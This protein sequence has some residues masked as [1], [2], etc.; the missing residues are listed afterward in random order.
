MNRSAAPAEE[1]RPMLRLE[2]A[3]RRPACLPQPGPAAAHRLPSLWLWQEKAE[4]AAKPP[5]K[6]VSTYAP[7]KGL[8]E[9]EVI[10]EEEFDA[11]RHAHRAKGGDHDSD[12]FEEETLPKHMRTGDLGEMLQ[13]AHLDHRIQ[14][15]FDGDTDDEGRGRTRHRRPARRRRPASAATATCADAMDAAVRPPR[16]R[17]TAAADPRAAPRSSPTCPS[18]AT[19]SSPARRFS[20]RSPRSL[21]PRRARASPRTSRCPAAS[22]SSCPPSRTSASAARSPPTRSASA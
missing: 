8:I 2:R 14:L 22:W 10:E 6:P 18:S 13:E 1:S 9:E 11:P 20:S 16:S 3:K 12:D 19:C 17:P 15:N 7:G 21:S 5:A 4:E